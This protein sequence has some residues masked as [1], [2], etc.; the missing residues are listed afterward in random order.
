M[1][2]HA[3]AQGL[4]L[5]SEGRHFE[6]ISCFESALAAKPDDTAVLFALGNTAQALGMTAPAAE[7]FR[8]VLA[9]EPGRIEALIHLANLFRA[10]GQFDGARALLEPA[11][12]RH[13]ESAELRL[14]L[15]SISRE[16]GDRE[17]AK[18]FYR[19]ALD[20]RSDYDFALSNLADLLAVD[21][22]FVTA[23]TL[24]DRALKAGKGHAQI[25]LNRAILHLQ[26]GNL[27]EGWRDYAARTSIPNKVP[28]TDLK[29]GEWRGT[30][31][32]RTRLLVRAEQGV[33]DQLMFIES[34]P[35]S[36]GPCL[37][38]HGNSGM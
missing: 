19:A 35:R 22:D 7:F 13:P 32:D 27:A 37:P 4:K 1:Y 30:P 33:G 31:L 3:Y 10:Q 29:L 2:A 5:S 18:H 12:A 34:D 16:A 11:L 15:G 8:K 17:Q 21:G 20:L 23:R 6:A 28:V 36:S 38:G 9:Q 24:Y 25:R 26:M 14:T